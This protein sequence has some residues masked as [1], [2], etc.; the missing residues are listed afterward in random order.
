[1]RRHPLRP[2]L[3][4][5]FLIALQTLSAC[6]T[7]PNPLTPSHRPTIASPLST[8]ASPIAV[9]THEGQRGDGGPRYQITYDPFLWEPVD[10]DLFGPALRYQGTQSECYLS[11]TGGPNEEEDFVAEKRLGNLIWRIFKEPT[12]ADNSIHYGYTSMPYI[13]GFIVYGESAKSEVALC[14]ESG[15]KLLAT[16][17][18]AN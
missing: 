15:E 16:L 8:I 10:S 2:L 5:T 11:L 3:M 18:P 7:P 4:A 13:V 9:A 17:V 6:H 1:M 12:V 14:L